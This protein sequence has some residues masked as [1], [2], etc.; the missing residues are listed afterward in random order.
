MNHLQCGSGNAVNDKQHSKIC[1]KAWET[2]EKS[3]L[4]SIE[5]E[6]NLEYLFLGKIE[7]NLF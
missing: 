7:W 1:S 3:H 4:N 5:I 2:L 6:E